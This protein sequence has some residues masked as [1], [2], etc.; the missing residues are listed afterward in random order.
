MVEA[1]VL[2]VLER[3]GGQEAVA[4]LAAAQH[5]AQ[6]VQRREVARPHAVHEEPLALAR[7]VQHS[8]R[9]LRA[10]SSTPL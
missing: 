5:A 7:Q 6:L 4:E 2:K 3:D 9:A 10:G 8:R 1:A